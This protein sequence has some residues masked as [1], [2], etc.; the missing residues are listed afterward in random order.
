MLSRLSLILLHSSF[1]ANFKTPLPDAFPVESFIF[2]SRTIGKDSPVFFIA[3]IAANHDGDLSRAKKL[4]TLAKESGADAVKFQH[5]DVS[6]YVSSSGLHPLVKNL[7]ISLP[8]RSRFMM[9]IR[10]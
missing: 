2:G 1:T 8:G 4:I 7:A 3:D 9:S 6:K 5:H 10:C